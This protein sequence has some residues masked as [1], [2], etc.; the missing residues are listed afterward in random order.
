MAKFAPTYPPA[1]QGAGIEGYVIVEY[2]VD[3]DGRPM[4]IRVIESVPEGLFDEASIAATKNFHYLPAL[5]EGV[6]VE[7]HGVQNKFTFELEPPVE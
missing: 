4:N 1:A 3:F 5:D 7:R 6:P 2:C